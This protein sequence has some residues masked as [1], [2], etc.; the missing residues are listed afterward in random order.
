MASMLH[1]LLALLHT[2]HSLFKSHRRLAL[3]N[4]V[5]RQQLAML[6]QSVKQPRVSLTDRFLGCCY[7]NMLKDGAR[8]CTR[9]TLILSF[10][11]IAKVFGVIGAVRVSAGA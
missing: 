4:L 6:K 1:L 5:L 2:A 3:E 11:C 9:C 7:R 10:A 8:C